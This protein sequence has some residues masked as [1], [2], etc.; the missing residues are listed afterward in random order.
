MAPEAGRNYED[1]LGRDAR[2]ISVWTVAT[3]VLPVWALVSFLP[4][5]NAPAAYGSVAQV[6]AHTAFFGT[7][8]IGLLGGYMMYRW[9]LADAARRQINIPTRAQR[10]RRVVLLTVYAIIWMALYFGFVSATA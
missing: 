10:M 9:M 4:L 5:F 7:G 3:P 6:L 2:D 1:T 8:A